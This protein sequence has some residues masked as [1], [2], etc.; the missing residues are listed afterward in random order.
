M[1][2]L[3][4]KNV[5]LYI[6]TNITFAVSDSTNVI[7]TVGNLNDI[8]DMSRIILPN[9]VTREHFSLLTNGQEGGN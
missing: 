4:N 6:L 8:S 2:S 5:N 7:F 9:N 1:M 3:E